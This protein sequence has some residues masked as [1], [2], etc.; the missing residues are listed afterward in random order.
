[1]QIQI[2]ITERV[3]I[4]VGGAAEKPNIRS[5]IEVA[6]PPV[7]NR[8]ASRV[9]SFI[10]LKENVCDFVLKRTFYSKQ[11]FKNACYFSI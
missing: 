7:F 1:M 2:L 4:G 11:G 3:T 6:K 8:E 10:C 9:E 5:N